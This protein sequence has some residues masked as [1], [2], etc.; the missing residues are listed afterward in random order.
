MRAI[1]LLLV[2]MLS[3]SV[4]RP[5]I[6]SADAVQRRLDDVCAMLSGKPLVYDTIF[7]EQFLRQVPAIQLTTIA[8]DRK[9]VV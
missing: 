9:S 4:A 3:T 2:V 1:T 7:S 8:Q 6:S 5:M